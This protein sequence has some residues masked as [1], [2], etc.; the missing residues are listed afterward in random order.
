MRII[1]FALLFTLPILLTGQNIEGDWYGQLRFKG[2]QLPLVIHIQAA[3][4]GYTATLDSP[5]QGAEGLPI[6]ETSFTNNQ[7]TLNAPTLGIVYKGT[8]QSESMQIEGTFEQGGAKIPLML[9]RNPSEEEA[10]DN[11]RPQD[12]QEFPYQQEE[13][14]FAN[15]ADKVTLAGTL[16]LPAEDSVTAVVIL[17]SGSGG[18]DRNEES[19]GLN[20]RPFLVL[21]DYLTRQGIGVLRYDDRGVGASGGSRKFAT[22]YDYAEDAAAAVRYLRQR[23][24]MKDVKIGI[25]GHSEGGMVAPL[26]ATEIEPIDF[27]VL[28]AAPGIPIDQLML[29]QSSKLASVSGIPADIQEANQKVLAESYQF[30]KASESLDTSIIRD[31]LVSILERGVASF[32]PSTREDIGDPNAFATAEAQEMMTPWFLYFMRFDPAKYLSKVNVPVLA[33]NGSLDLQVPAEENLAAIRK[34]LAKAEK[35]AVSIKTFEG[36]NHL[37]QSATTGSVDEYA[38]IEETFNEA[39]MKYVAEWINKL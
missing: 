8:Y 36:L 3:D 34:S 22:T 21:S 29:L 35:E 37:F 33:V 23:E 17:V 20:H 26:V 16:T 25:A 2:T 14:A 24:D 11:T 39:A 27:M 12:P 13:V 30:L 32:P 28:L 31:S 15:E 1:C 10:A 4:D 9:S 5:M 18:Q 19:P 6:G 7:L 38:E